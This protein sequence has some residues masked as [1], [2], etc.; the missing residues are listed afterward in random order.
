[1]LAEAARRQHTG[2]PFGGVI[3][4]HQ[5]DVSIGQCVLDL[6][7]ITEIGTEADV[8]NQIIYLPL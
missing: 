8:A 6:Q 1:L 7:I 2:I 5:R 3:Y 4:T